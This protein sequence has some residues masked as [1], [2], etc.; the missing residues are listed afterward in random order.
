V[1]SW[2]QTARVPI[3]NVYA[4]DNAHI[5]PGRAGGEAPVRSTT[6]AALGGALIAS[7]DVRQQK[8]CTT[9]NGID[10]ISPQFIWLQGGCVVQCSFD[11]GCLV[12]EFWQW[13]TS[14]SGRQFVWQFLKDLAAIA[15]VALTFLKWWERREAYVFGRLSNILGEQATYTRDALR[16]VVQRMRRPGP[17]DSPKMPI[18][19]EGPLRRLFGRR[20]WKPVFALAEPLT[21]ADRKLRRLHRKL[22]MRQRAATNYQTFVSEQRFAAYMLQGAIALG[23][24]ESTATD[25]RL[26]RLNEIANDRFQSALQVVGKEND[27]DALELR[28]LLLRKLGQIDVNGV[29]GAHQ[30][31]QQLQAAAVAQFDAA[32]ISDNER[33]RDLKSVIIRAARY[34]AEMLH[35]QVPATAV[36]QGMLTAVE[37]FAADGDTVTGQRL[38]DRARYF[39]VNSCIRVALIMAAG[40]GIGP[41][42]SKRINA[43]KKAYQLLRDD[44]DPKSWDWPTR[45]WR[46]FARLF[47]DDGAKVMLREAKS[48]LARM[49]RIVLKQGCPICTPG[50]QVDATRTATPDQ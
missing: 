9:Q 34:Q 27:L 37:P 24:T 38:L 6:Y 20:H 10:I 47:R 2:S 11:F 44:S 23:R 12:S 13:V 32:N 36:G 31:F 50:Y 48:G 39:E 49:D 26:N 7:L 42:A 46:A 22:E 28:G 5:R 25:I 45:V 1:S 35:S 14:D 33:R 30:T 21:S 16:F 17:A 41:E 8:P 3:D 40:Q 43:A 15:G 4:N 18:F 29:G 19:A